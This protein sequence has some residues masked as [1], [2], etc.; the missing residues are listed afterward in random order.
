LRAFKVQ[1]KRHPYYLLPGAPARS[2]AAPTIVLEHGRVQAVLGCTGSE[3]LPS[4]IMATLVRLERQTAFEAVHG[5]RMHCTPE[6][7]V[8]LESDGNDQAVVGALERAGLAVELLT[9]YSFRMGGIQ[10][11]AAHGGSYQGVADP[12][13]DGAA[14]AAS[15]PTGP[16]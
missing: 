6:G 13:R 7:L 3:R 9:R 11:V 12:R 4:G 5:P 10:L 15:L 14:L 8:L 16:R 1:N 2:N